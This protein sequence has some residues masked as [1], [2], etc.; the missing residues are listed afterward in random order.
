MR[1]R[2]SCT[3]C[4]AFS[5]ATEEN[6]KAYWHFLWSLEYYCQLAADNEENNANCFIETYCGFARDYTDVRIL[7]QCLLI[8]QSTKITG[9]VYKCDRNNL[10]KLGYRNVNL[11]CTLDIKLPYLYILP[12]SFLHFFIC[13]FIRLNFLFHT[14]FFIICIFL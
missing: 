13:K 9:L 2:S 3:P 11:K 7:I 12:I 14:A 10:F 4:F 1:A 6:R 8:S 5:S